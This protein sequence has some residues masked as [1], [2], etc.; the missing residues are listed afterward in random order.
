MLRPLRRLSGVLQ[1]CER[2]RVTKRLQSNQRAGMPDD[3]TGGGRPQLVNLHLADGLRL[4]G[5]DASGLNMMRFV[6]ACGNLCFVQRMCINGEKHLHHN[7]NWFDYFTYRQCFTKVDFQQLGQFLTN[8]VGNATQLMANDSEGL[9][10]K[11]KNRGCECCSYKIL[12]LKVMSI[13]RR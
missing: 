8:A 11:S 12:H 4:Q 10:L 3:C 6:P 1:K 5:L 13:S 9:I 7:M 2:T